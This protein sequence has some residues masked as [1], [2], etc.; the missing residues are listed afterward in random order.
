MAM[1]ATAYAGLG[2][3]VIVT[4]EDLLP[5]D[6]VIKGFKSEIRDRDITIINIK[7]GQNETDLVSNMLALKPELIICIGTKALEEISKIRGIAKI[8]SLV[9]HAT[10]LR[11]EDRMDIAGVCLDIPS[12]DQ[13]KILKKAFPELNRIGAIYDPR[14]NKKL[15]QEAERSGSMLNLHLVPSPVNSIKDIPGALYKLE[16]KIDVLW[17]F[18][19]QTVYTPDTAK[20]ILLFSLRRN[21]P[22]VGFS[23]Q[24]AK[25]GALIALYGDYGDMGR[26]AALLVKELSE[27]G[28]WQIRRVEPRRINVAINEKVARIMR[29]S[30]SE[31]FLR[32][33]NKIY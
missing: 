6:E 25:A 29:I 18:C 32:T 5:Y 8:F 17:S 15:M 28:T 10:A 7:S 14:Q 23:P 33:V 21:I 1:S 24:F 11:Y 19:D 31:S 4:T 16:N 12:A 2:R 13:F 26:Q 30:F 22:F 27:T 20:Y 3:V 9:N